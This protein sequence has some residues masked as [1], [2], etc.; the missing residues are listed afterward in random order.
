M[1]AHGFLSPSRPHTEA[2]SAR[3]EKKKD[4][5]QSRPHTHQLLSENIRVKIIMMLLLLAYQMQRR[6]S[7]AI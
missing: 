1:P 7:D 5:S 3:H 2:R 6:R 4:A